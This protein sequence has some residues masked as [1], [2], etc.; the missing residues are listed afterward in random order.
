MS[1][2]FYGKT[3][4]IMGATGCVGRVLFRTLLKEGWTIKTLARSSSEAGWLTKEGAE[5]IMGDITDAAS[6]QQA[7]QGSNFV[8]NLLGINDSH[9][10][11]PAGQPPLSLCA[12]A[13]AEAALRVGVERFLFLSDSIVYGYDPG[14][15]TN[16]AHPISASRDPAIAERVRAEQAVWKAHQRGLPAVILQPT[17]IYGPYA[18]A[19]T[20]R[21]IRLIEAGALTCPN[22][23]RGLLQPI[24]IYDVIEGFL[25]AALVSEPGQAY[26]LP[27]S[28]TVTCRAFLD[29]YAHMLGKQEVPATPGGIMSV[30]TGKKSPLEPWQVRSAS[31]EATYNGGKA[32][33]EMG[34]LPR[35]TLEDGMRRTAE[36]L[37]KITA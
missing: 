27:G 2:E 11:P 30:L 16:E 5:A 22:Q 24:H 17:T 35:Y 8:F 13:A 12:K 36:W 21:L 25:T 14:K 1:M 32:Y 10:P 6:L 26:L 31:M 34:F 9:A 29:S 15:D 3:I 23:G 18:D 7:M 28:E 20:L 33:F 19:W 37:R 4:F